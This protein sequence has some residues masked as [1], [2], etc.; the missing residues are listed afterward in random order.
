MHWAA[1]RLETLNLAA[2]YKFYPNC[3]DAGFPIWWGDPLVDHGPTAYGVVLIGM[4]ERTTPQAVGQ[5]APALFDANTTARVIACQFPRNS[6]AM[7]LD[8]VFT[9][10]DRDLVTVFAEVTDAIQP[11]SMRPRQ[12]GQD[13]RHG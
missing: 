6:S 5:V 7:H 4:G 3:R 1:W 2:I 9:Y 8:T 11:Y 12:S 13:R 10:C